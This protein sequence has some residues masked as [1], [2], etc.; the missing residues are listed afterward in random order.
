MTTENS[1]LIENIIN[2]KILLETKNLADLDNKDLENLGLIILNSFYQEKEIYINSI[3]SNIKDEYKGREN[4]ISY[5]NFKEDFI[6]KQD[7]IIIMENHLQGAIQRALTVYK[8]I[9][10]NKRQQEEIR[11]CQQIKDLKYDN[12]KFKTNLIQISIIFFSTIITFLE[13]VKSIFS[14]SDNV[15][16]TIISVLLS[17]YIGLVMAVSRFFKYDDNKEVLT[18]LDE[19]QTFAI[20]RLAYR[21][22]L[23]ERYL[24]ITRFTNQ[25]NIVKLID[26]FSKD[27]LDEIISQTYQEYDMNLT[28]T[29]KLDY[30]DNWIE[31]KKKDL[32]QLKKS[33]ELINKPI[34]KMNNDEDK[35]TQVEMTQVETTQKNIDV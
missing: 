24:P 35:N 21:N 1:D 9:K 15:T 16:I 30:T 19:K 17:M 2:E 20:N 34:Q 12:L 22:E 4:D 26:E 14:L 8:N 33:N 27:G 32:I 23:L 10:Y 6:K 7:K 29:E 11:K 3:E 31:L 25:D 28:F 5:N 13:S 18:K